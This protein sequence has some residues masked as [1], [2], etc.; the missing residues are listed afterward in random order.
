MVFSDF[1]RRALILALPPGIDYTVTQ[2]S[3]GEWNVALADL[4]LGPAV[5]IE[6]DR[7]C[8]DLQ[9]RSPAL[10]FTPWTAPHPGAKRRRV[11][12]AMPPP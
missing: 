8:R 5:G 3:M 1:V 9:A 6:I 11:R 4:S 10:S 2:T 7:L 12:R